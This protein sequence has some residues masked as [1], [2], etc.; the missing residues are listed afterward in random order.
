VAC[1]DSLTVRL[2]SNGTYVAG[3]Y[4]AELVLSEDASILAEFELVTSNSNPSNLNIHVV[5][6]DSYISSW[7]M[8]EEFHDPLLIYYY[9]SLLSDHSSY[10]YEFPQEVTMNIRKDGAVMV[11]ESI[12][13]DYN[14]YWCNEE[15]GECDD[16]QN[17]NADVDMTVDLT[18]D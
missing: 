9:G 1:R 8:S 2:S 4:S 17:K 12:T 7:S 13:P 5:M 11:S 10:D 14:Y 15:E 6:N 16:R 3:Q 18:S